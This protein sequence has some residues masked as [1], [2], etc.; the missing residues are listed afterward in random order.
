MNETDRH[1]LDPAA[2]F[3]AQ[4]GITP[5][6]PF[7]ADLRHNAWHPRFHWQHSTGE[8]AD[9]INLPHED[10]P[11]RVGD[12]ERALIMVMTRNQSHLQEHG[13]TLP[14]TLD[15][16]RDV[17]RAIFADHG[18]AAGEWRRL[19]VRVADHLAPSHQ[20]LDRLMRQLEES[21]LERELHLQDLRDWYF[22]FETIH[23]FRDGN[24][25]VGGVIIAALSFPAW[26]KF[27]TPG[28]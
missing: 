11:R 27:L 24:G 22:D 25:R 21:Y 3:T 26:G 13:R 20:L 16:V 14:I 15:L 10:Y 23:P 4:A 18:R 9:R 1:N 5:Q 12:T 8:A 19:E 2:S 7:F 17:H 6:P 28:Q